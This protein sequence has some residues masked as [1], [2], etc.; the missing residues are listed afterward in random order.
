MLRRHQVMDRW[1]T[2]LQ[3]SVSQHCASP[4]SGTSCV[5]CSDSSAL[6]MVN[7][8]PAED[9][10]GNRCLGLELSVL[11]SLLQAFTGSRHMTTDSRLEQK[12]LFWV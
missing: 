12:S 9:A 8:P 10:D 5:N 3:H 7:R 4:V 1:Q 11:S 2:R 6:D